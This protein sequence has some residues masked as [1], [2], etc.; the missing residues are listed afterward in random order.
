MAYGVIDTVMTGHAS[1]TDLAAMGLGA[2]V[3]G[4]VFVGL[5]GVMGALNPIIAQH[6]GAG[7]QAEIGVDYVQGFWLA[8]LISGPGCVVLGVPELWLSAVGAA[9]EVNALVSRYLRVLSVGLP[10]A[11]MFRAVYALNVALARPKVVM[12]LQLAALMLKATLSYALIFGRL[13]VLCRSGA[14]KP[15]PG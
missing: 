8:L 5:M 12:A 1:P 9:P 13:G 4:T 14:D 3:Y 11:L 2:S 15:I 10:A 7:R 6:H